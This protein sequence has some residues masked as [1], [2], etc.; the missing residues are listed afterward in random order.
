MEKGIK[1][2]FLLLVGILFSLAICGTV[3]ADPYLGGDNLTTIQTGTVSGGVYSDS[4][5]GTNGTAAP[6]SSNTGNNINNV[7]Y[8]FVE[9][10][11]NAQA[12]NAT[13][14]VTVYSGIMDVNY[15]VDVNVTFNGQH[16]GYEH[17]SSTYTFPMGSGTI[18]ALTINDHCNRVTSDYMMWYDV[19]SLVEQN[20]IANVFTQSDNDGRVK[21]ITLII[22]YDDGDSDSI[23]YWLNQGHDVDSYKTDDN[24]HID[25]IGSTSFESA[26]PTG[27][28]IN[29]AT[30][31]VYHMASGDGAYTFN[32]NVVV[33]RQ[34]QQSYTGSNTWD[35]TSYFN[36][37]GTN[38]MTYNRGGS[39]YKIILALLTVNYTAPVDMRPDLLVS[40]VEVTGSP[41]VNQNHN[42]TVT[43]NNAGQTSADN[44]AVKLIDNGQELENRTVNTLNSG[45]SRI[46][47]FTW[48]PTTTGLHNLE[49]VIDALEH[50]AE[51]DETNNRLIKSLNVEPERADL[52]GSALT[53]P[54]DPE[55]NHIYPLT[56]TISNTGLADAGS[57]KV[58]L[59]DGSTFI[60]R[61]TINSLA[62]GASATL[63]F[64]WKPTSTGSHTL[65]LVVDSDD[66]VDESDETNNQFNRYLIM[67]EG[68]LIN[69]FIISDTSS[70]NTINMAA[71][72][73]LKNL[74]GIV[75]IQ[76]RS[77]E[78]VEA[79]TADELR[80][81][82]DS[83]DIFIGEWVSTDG[84]T[85]LAQVLQNYPEVANKENGLFLVLEPPVSTETSSVELMKYSTI[86]GVKILENFTNEELINYYQKTKQG[87]LY[88]N[89]T[90]YLET[91]NFPELFNT[92]I[93]YKDLNDKANY[94]NQILWA[95]NLMGL[96]VEYEEPTFSSEKQ[97]YGI[98]RYRWYTLEEYLEKYVNSARQGTVGII[99]S[100][101][102][103]DGEM[104]QT[105]YAIIEALEA[106]GLNVI[107]VTAYGGTSAQL[108]VMV[109]AFTSAPDYTS[110]MADP[111]QYEIYV[112]SIVEMVAYGLGED[113][114]VRL[115]IFS[116]PST[117][118][119]YGLSILML[120]LMRS[121]NW[122][123][124]DF[125][126]MMGVNGGMW[127]Y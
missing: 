98:Y 65:K 102:Y 64:N 108:E 54:D 73:L 96:V 94:E 35:V 127:P 51:T 24:L 92:A 15:P 113:P 107:P 43:I 4:Y 69:V 32:G 109:Q 93:L 38:N 26:L 36:S 61:G 19:T 48:T 80:A 27:S 81:Y 83:C 120:S 25:Y 11:D 47:T 53:I 111:S 86:N 1:I 29:N 122:K 56:A 44:F 59:Y 117:C 79:M 70:T 28:T 67:N 60:G 12:V 20:N 126:M 84:G 124:L 123:V 58:E 85:L 77:D 40:K 76:I 68:N 49:L 17:L 110:F 103:V 37:F 99:E 23:Q 50:V 63:I 106:Q 8:E 100:T 95:L 22:A 7:T 66:Q 39:Y 34:V 9:L 97:A 30:L 10:P 101:K 74:E 18:E 119:W 87:E 115:L 75:S 42:L 62:E 16:V 2:S 72:E 88:A 78:Q 121:G 6:G 112:D 114:S 33:G 82:L 45:S 31:K 116:V 105:Y 57:F 14:Y 41:V 71:Q 104:L 55:V 5:Y 118:Q 125:P 89:I 52:V 13:L 21:L 91:V 3:S 46:L 90:Q